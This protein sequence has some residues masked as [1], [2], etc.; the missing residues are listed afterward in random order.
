MTPLRLIMPS[1]QLSGIDPA[2]LSP[3]E[4]S[5]HTQSHSDTAAGS[6]TQ[7]PCQIGPALDSPEFNRN[8]L[9]DNGEVFARDPHGK[10]CK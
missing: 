8:P 4:Q 7:V 3:T 5:S 10:F 1:D 9:V 6:N 2:I